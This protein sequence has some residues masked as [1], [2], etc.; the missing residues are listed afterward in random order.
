MLPGANELPTPTP[1]ACQILTC[2][3]PQNQ[4][5]DPSLYP[6]PASSKTSDLGDVEVSDPSAVVEKDVKTNTIRPVK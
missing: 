4:P 3:R 2:F 1:S 5:V 6:P